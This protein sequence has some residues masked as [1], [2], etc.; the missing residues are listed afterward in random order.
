MK[1]LW[2]IICSHIAI[3]IAL[4][5]MF[6]CYGAINSSS[7]VVRSVNCTVIFFSCLIKLRMVPKYKYSV[8]FWGAER[9]SVIYSVQHF[10]AGITKPNRGIFIRVLRLIWL[11]WNRYKPITRIVS[12]FII[13]M[14]KLIIRF[15]RSF[16]VVFNGQKYLCWLARALL[17]P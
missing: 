8:V 15:F 17:K 16:R 5:E 10:W 7:A 1:A 4:S 13:L 6:R 14:I 9:E 3:G 2:L 12:S 11:F